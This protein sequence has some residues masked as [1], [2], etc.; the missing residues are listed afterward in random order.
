[1][2]GTELAVYS[3]RMWLYLCFHSLAGNL[4]RG[5]KESFILT[6]F[7]IYVGFVLLVVAVMA[8]SSLELLNLGNWIFIPGRAEHTMTSSL[9]AVSVSCP[10]YAF[11]N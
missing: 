3:F 6:M 8:V 11:R 5:W 1:M 4:S 7:K 10:K 2:M 9:K